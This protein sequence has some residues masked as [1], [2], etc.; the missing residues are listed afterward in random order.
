MFVPCSFLF[1]AFWFW[2]LKVWTGK[3]SILHL[4][5]ET[6]EHTKAVSSL[7]ILQSKEILYSGSLDKTTRAWSI[8]NEGIQCVEVH[9]MKDQVHNL[10]VTNSFSCFIPQSNGIKVLK[11]IMTFHMIII[12]LPFT[13][14]GIH[15]II[16]TLEAR[17]SMQ[18][19]L[20]C[21]LLL[22]PGS[23]MEWRI[24]NV[25]FGQICKVL[26]SGK[27]ENILWMPW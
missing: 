14:S 24:Q 3:G 8:S 6:Q 4:I 2:I 9:D 18:Q 25:K 11:E 12:L 19:F 23:L 22:F 20:M 15:A 16:S 13:F 21:C 27:W 17:K 7:A 5:Q 10:A 26:C 1:M